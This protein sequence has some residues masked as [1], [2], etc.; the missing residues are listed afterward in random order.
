METV[1]IESTFRYLRPSRWRFINVSKI[2]R[3]DAF[4]TLH[5]HLPWQIDSQKL[6]RLSP[7]PGKRHDKPV[8]A[9]EWPSCLVWADITRCIGMISHE[10][11]E[12]PEINRL[13]PTTPSKLLVIHAAALS[14][15]SNQKKVL[16]GENADCMSTWLKDQ[17]AKPKT[18]T[19]RVRGQRPKI[20]DIVLGNS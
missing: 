18:Q 3:S 12:T 10:S 15:V 19:A 4:T 9:T 1:D 11:V 16:R 2:T 13:E 8:T 17:N 20:L 14:S 7:S 5:L 6:P